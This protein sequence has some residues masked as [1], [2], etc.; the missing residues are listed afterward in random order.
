MTSSSPG[1]SGSG[2]GGGGGGSGGG[3]GAF[4]DWE[5]LPAD[6][7]CKVLLATGNVKAVAASAAGAYTRPL[8]S[9]T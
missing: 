4:A 1:G 8:L 9:S 5:N 7:L 6:V 2:S 3:A